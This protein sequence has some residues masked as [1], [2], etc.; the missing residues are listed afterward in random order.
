M[1]AKKTNDLLVKI[2]RRL[3]KQ[4]ITVATAESC[5]GGLLAGAL[6][7]LPGSSKIF[8]GGVVAYDNEVKIRL[9]QIPGAIIERYGVRKLMG[10]KFALS[11]TGIAGPD[12]GSAAKPVGTVWVGFADENRAEARLLQLEGSRDEIRADSVYESLMVLDSKM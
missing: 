2:H 11:V 1:T 4:G 3:V 7:Q 6:T 5:T 12:G 8:L 10:A 9:L